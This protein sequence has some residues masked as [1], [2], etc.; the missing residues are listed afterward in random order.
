M[1]EGNLW[2]IVSSVKGKACDLNKMLKE[3]IFQKFNARGSKL[4]PHF[5]IK[6]P[7][8]I[9]D[10]S[11]IENAIDKFSKK[12]T[13]EKYVIDGFNH[14]SS[15]VVYMDVKMSKEAKAVHDL[16]I[17]ELLKAGLVFDKKDGKKKVFH[18]T[19]VS[20]NVQTNF[21][22]IWEYILEFKCYFELYF[23]NVE[24]YKFQNNRWM[25]Y[26]SFNFK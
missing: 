18:V 9:D 15:R 26:R 13:R 24:I 17:D 23:D 14:F 7:F 16:L 21:E 5:T 11:D 2:V 6:A 20:K 19:I 1:R 22:H 25:L 10:I 8:E 12:A 3:N 4:P